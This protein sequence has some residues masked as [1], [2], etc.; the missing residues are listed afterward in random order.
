MFLTILTGCANNFAKYYH[1]FSNTREGKEFYSG[2]PKLLHGGNQRNDF[3]RMIED[4]YGLIGVSSFNSGSGPVQDA[5]A[6]ARDNGAEVVIYY[7]KYTH[8]VSGNIPYTVQNPNQ[9][10]TSHGSGDIYGYGG[11]A[12][13]NSTTTSTVPGG[14]TTYDI[15]YSID[16]HDFLAAY[17]SKNK[18]IIFGTLVKDLPDDIK[19]QLERNR[20]AIV[21]IVVKNSPAFNADVLKGDI[22]SKI[23]GQDISDAKDFLNRLKEKSGKDVEI[24]IIRNGAV[25]V[26]R[27]KLN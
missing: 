19:R 25:K 8:T 3:N 18:K 9:T 11:S 1:S 7:S 16:R 15:P 4:G 24:E 10:I 6:V 20:G 14:S 27:L 12:T 2:Q 23:D 21:D 5:I 17:W 26:I 13:Y 22:I